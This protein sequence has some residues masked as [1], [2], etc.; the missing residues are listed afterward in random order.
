MKK[1]RLTALVLLLFMFFVSL[2]LGFNYLWALVPEVNDG[3]GNFSLLHKVFGVFGDHGWSL[4]RYLRAFQISAWIT[5]A[6]L[7]FN[8]ILNRCLAEKRV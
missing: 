3:I 5:F 6:L 7:V 8:I 1:V 2:D 4:G